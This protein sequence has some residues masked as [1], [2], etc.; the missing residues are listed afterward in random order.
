M[1]YDDALDRWVV[2]DDEAWHSLHYGDVIHLHVG[3]QTLKGRLEYG[4]AWYLNIEGVI[5]GLSKWHRYT[6]T[7]EI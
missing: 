3:K 2:E 6:V 5:L 7:I 1:G 4:L